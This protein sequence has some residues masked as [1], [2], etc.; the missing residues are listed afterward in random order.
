MGWSV[1]LSVFMP[2]S[3]KGA[4]LYFVFLYF[5]LLIMIALSL[6]R[7]FTNSIHDFMSFVHKKMNSTHDFMN[8][9]FSTP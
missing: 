2:N 5:R 6:I 8:C 1:E 7:D 4:F 9:Y 3:I